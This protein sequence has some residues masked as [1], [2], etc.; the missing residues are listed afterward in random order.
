MSDKQGKNQ[1][2]KSYAHDIYGNIIIE[3]KHVGDNN[4]DGN[5]LKH[6]ISPVHA[7]IELSVL[8]NSQEQ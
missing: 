1:T 5:E 4:A 3:Q 6:G 8:V 2:C 7:G